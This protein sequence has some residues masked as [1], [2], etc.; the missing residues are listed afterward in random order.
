M[1]RK[2]PYDRPLT[3]EDRAYLEMRGEHARVEQ[4]DRDYPPESD[5][6]VD[7]DDDQEMEEVEDYADWKKQ[8]LVAEAKERD[9]DSSGTAEELRARLMQHDA[10]TSEGDGE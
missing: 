2:V 7:E 5:V 3:D 6:D 8:D 10:E 1:S 9:L 4:L